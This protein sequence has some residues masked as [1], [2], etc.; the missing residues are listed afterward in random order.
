MIPTEEGFQ[1][2][3]VSKSLADKD[4]APNQDNRKKNGRKFSLSMSKSGAVLLLFIIAVSII[5]T[6]FIATKH[7]DAHTRQ[8]LAYSEDNFFVWNE[9][10]ATRVDPHFKPGASADLVNNSI[11]IKAAKNEFESTQFILWNL[12]QDNIQNI[13]IELSPF[14]NRNGQTVVGT[15]NQSV[16]LVDLIRGE[17]FDRIL[18]LSEMEYQFSL[19]ESRNFPLWYTVY[20]PKDVSS[21]IYHANFTITLDQEE[22]HTIRLSLE[23]Y[24]FALP[25]THSYQ[26]MVN[27][28][29]SNTNLM[30]NFFN[31][32]IDFGGVPFNV[33]FNASTMLWD[34]EWERWDELTEYAF[35]QGQNQIKLGSPK[36][37]LKQFE[38]FSYDYNFS[39]ITFYAKVASHLESKG[40]LDRAYVYYI[41]EPSVEECVEF[42]RICELIHSVDQDLRILLT[43][44]PRD[45]ISFLYDDINIWAPIEHHLDRYYEN[46]KYLQ[47][48]GADIVYY[49]CL[50]PKTP[51]ANIMVYNQLIDTKVLGWQVF[52]YDIDG[53]LYWHTA[54]YYHN[55]HGYGYN[56]WLDGWLIYPRNVSAGVYDSSIRWE[57]LRDGFEDIEYF[58]ILK[59]LN[60]TRP[61]YSEEISAVLNDMKGIMKDFRTF[62]QDP[63][64]YLQ[65]R[66]RV[67][68]LIDQIKSA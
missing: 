41:D 48:K 18:P 67:A 38:K 6:Y 20:V 12:N 53:F 27:P 59:E 23:V 30:Q 42:E 1:V 49:P 5:P 25:T 63:H 66:E 16:G 58:Y 51:Y 57:A 14:V 47:S 62:S 61:L 52:Y 22:T 46:L 50:F 54:A 28:M 11:T 15:Q 8:V 60:Q 39:L 68:N 56:S 29:T 21:G 4:L 44:A 7:A 64:D 24:N 36:G 10:S 26:T 9:D 37:F 3:K 40:W 2:S 33:S 19:N 31:H 43:T 55:M 32:K 45:E 34:F 17:F 35:S 13:E 65:Y